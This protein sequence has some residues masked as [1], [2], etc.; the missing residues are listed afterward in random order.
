MELID[1]VEL[2]TGGCAAIAIIQLYIRD[3]GAHVFRT[4]KEL[5]GFLKVEPELFEIMMGSSSRD[6]RLFGKVEYRW[7]ADK[8]PVRFTKAGMGL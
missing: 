8:E 3:F 4:L 1:G 6:I 5:K 7:L 2:H